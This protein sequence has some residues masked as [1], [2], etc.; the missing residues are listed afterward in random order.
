LDLLY[1]LAA[2]EGQ[3]GGGIAAFL[4]FILI[5]VVI[6]F[7][8]IRPQSKRQKEKKQMIDNLKK[9]DR[10]ITIGGIHGSIA[11]FKNNGK[12]VILKIDKNMNI[13]VN[14]S[15]VAGLVG[16]VTEEDTQLDAQA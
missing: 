10:I 16:N 3:Q 6:Y 1:A 11:G 4:P 13:T 12:V 15:A 14:R 5:M 9:G 8:M 2:P 7:L